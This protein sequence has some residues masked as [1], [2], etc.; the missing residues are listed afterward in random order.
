MFIRISSALF[1]A[2]ALIGTACGEDDD[3][4]TGAECKAIGTTCHDV[5]T[6]LGQECHEIGHDNVASVCSERGAECLA[7]CEAYGAGGAGGAGGE[8]GSH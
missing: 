4:D 8:A 3:E 2:L 1:L 6:E 5:P 7:Y